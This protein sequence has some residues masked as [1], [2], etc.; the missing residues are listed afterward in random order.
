MENMKYR[1]EKLQRGIFCAVRRSVFLPVV[2]EQP[3][4]FLGREAS[5]CNA[6]LPRR[7]PEKL[8]CNVSVVVL[9]VMNRKCYV[10]W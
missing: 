1:T 9:T 7:L 8:Q 4:L 3:V 5:P 10:W 6:Y 2:R